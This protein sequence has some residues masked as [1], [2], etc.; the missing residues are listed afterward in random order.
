VWLV[1]NIHFTFANRPHF[2]AASHAFDGFKKFWIPTC[3]AGMYLFDLSWSFILQSLLSSIQIFAMDWI[4]FTQAGRIAFSQN[5]RYFEQKQAFENRPNI[6]LARTPYSSSVVLRARA[7]TG[8]TMPVARL[9]SSFKVY[10][11]KPP[12]RPSSFLSL[13][14][15]LDLESAWGPVLGRSAAAKL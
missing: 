13:K 14:Q 12:H 4:I 9:D 6:Q 8:G 11:V 2:P 3:S 5:D 1:L 7:A 15:E 10:F